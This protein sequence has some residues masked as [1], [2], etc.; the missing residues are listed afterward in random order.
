M[1]MTTTETEAQWLAT[2]Q[3]RKNATF[4]RRPV[5]VREML[6]HRR[7]SPAS[8]ELADQFWTLVFT[9]SH[10]EPDHPS[11]VLAEWY[12]KHPA[13]KTRLMRNPVAVAFHKQ[14]LKQWRRFVSASFGLEL[15]ATKSEQARNQRHPSRQAREAAAQGRPAARQGRVR[16][17]G[18]ALGS[19]GPLASEGP[20]GAGGVPWRVRVT[21]AG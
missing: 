12:Q 7:A 11:R 21:A 8:A 3:G 5:I 18:R 17:T 4:L 14:T 16:S 2:F 10:P 9:E 6:A 20:E 15:W 19:A 13:W 1:A